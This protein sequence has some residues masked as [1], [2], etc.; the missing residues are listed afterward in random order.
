MAHL[1]GRYMRSQWANSALQRS[2]QRML[3]RAPP[4]ARIFVFN[5][6]FISHSIKTGKK[7][8]LC[9][10]FGA[11]RV[12]THLAFLYLVDGLLRRSGEWPDDGSLTVRFCDALLAVRLEG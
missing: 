2:V 12:P 10:F 8:P 7:A 9:V 4:A 6:V 5:I 3:N 1:A 11:M